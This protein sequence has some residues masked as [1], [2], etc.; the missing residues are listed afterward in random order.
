MAGWAVNTLASRLSENLAAANL[1]SACGVYA[2]L[3]LS[4]ALASLAGAC[5]E[6]LLGVARHAASSSGSLDRVQLFGCTSTRNIPP[7][8]RSNAV[9]QRTALLM[10]LGGLPHLEP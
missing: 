9:I 4:R 2:R 8:T 7:C 3:T 1:W 10:G 5:L 6:F